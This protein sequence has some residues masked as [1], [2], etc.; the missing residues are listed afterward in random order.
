[1]ADLI[2]V[3]VGIKGLAEGEI[4]PLPSGGELVLGRSRL[5]SVSYQRFRRFLSLSP[6]EQKL[7]DSYNSAVSRRHLLIRATGVGAKVTLENLSKGGSWCDDQ[8]FDGL[9]EVDLAQRGVVLRLGQAVETFQL[10]LLDRVAIEAQLA[11]LGTP[12]Q[13]PAPLPGVPDPVEDPTPEQ[14][15][16]QPSGALTPNPV[17]S[18]RP[19]AG[20][21]HPPTP[22][23]PP[24]D[25]EA[26]RYL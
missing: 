11:R 15:Q 4:Y 1:M 23:T 25:L 21:Q 26:S 8:R 14:N 6:D 5:C 16:A 10:A 3:L 24:P 19:A 20:N 7:R 2:P 9:R 22:P 12:R 18:P 17:Q 13:P